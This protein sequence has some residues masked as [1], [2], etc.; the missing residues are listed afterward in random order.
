MYMYNI[1]GCTCTC[2]KFI[3]MNALKCRTL[4]ELHECISAQLPSDLFRT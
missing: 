1:L 3:I 4:T 2:N